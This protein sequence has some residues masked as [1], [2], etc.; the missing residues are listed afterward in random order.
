MWRW[1]GSASRAE[2]KR[3]RSAGPELDRDRCSADRSCG[4]R[5]E[6]TSSK[7]IT[8]DELRVLEDLECESADRWTELKVKEPAHKGAK[9]Q[10]LCRESS[11]STGSRNSVTELRAFLVLPV[12]A[13]AAFEHVFSGAFLRSCYPS[14]GFEVSAAS[15]A[16]GN[17]A[18][19][20]SDSSGRLELLRWRR[21]REDESGARTW[22]LRPAD[23]SAVSFAQPD[24]LGGAVA[25]RTSRLS[26]A[27]IA[28]LFM[29]TDIANGF[30][31]RP[32]SETSP[33]LHQSSGQSCRLFL[34]V[35]LPGAGFVLRAALAKF[36]PG[37]LKRLCND[38][39]SL[40]AG[41]PLEADA[42]P[43]TVAEAVQPCAAADAGPGEGAPSVTGLAT[44]PYVHGRPIA[45]PRRPRRAQWT[46]R[47]RQAP[48]DEVEV[49][50]SVRT[51]S[52]GGEQIREAHSAAA[53]A[54]AWSSVQGYAQP[55]SLQNSAGR[56][57]VTTGT[58]HEEVGATPQHV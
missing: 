47:K 13:A 52:A 25:N 8:E 46:G 14:W 30:V 39:S 38:L 55:C 11:A 19:R 40:T 23:P 5:G 22:L 4:F 29:L 32:L 48:S 21:I 17:D 18:V 6:G 26:V 51:V 37:P 3:A 31:L 15:V 58:P 33:P 49:N 34:Y 16:S 56:G 50:R 28:D 10:L 36:C 44:Q 43:E 54:A 27:S 12:P 45:H 42:S 1:S 57:D 2:K 9:I 41:R 24:L 7:P 35:R 20:I 53:W